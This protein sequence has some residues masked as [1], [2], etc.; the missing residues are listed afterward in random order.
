MASEVGLNRVGLTM[1]LFSNSYQAFRGACR[2][3][4][5]KEVKQLKEG[6]AL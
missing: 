2:S 5:V 6:Y 3:V 4:N 1:G